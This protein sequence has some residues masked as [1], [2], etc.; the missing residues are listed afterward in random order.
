MSPKVTNYDIESQ[1]MTIALDTGGKLEISFEHEIIDLNGIGFEYNFTDDDLKDIFYMTGG[2][3]YSAA[4]IL[5]WAVV[6]HDDIRS[7]A[8][9]DDEDEDEY[10]REIS[11][12]YLSG[13]I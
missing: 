3:T 6:N 7:G 4:E 13:R 5:R 8:I 9:Q 11:S 10:I 1:A 2:E 12:P